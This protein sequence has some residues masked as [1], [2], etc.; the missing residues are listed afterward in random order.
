MGSPISK[1]G[2]ETPIRSKS[3]SSTG[4]RDVSIHRAQVLNVNTRDYTVDVRYESYPY[5]THSDIP[6][7]V[8]YLH[9]N[10]GEGIVAMPEVGSTVWVC[11]PSESGKDAFV[12]GWTPVQET[13]TYRAGRV[14]LNPGDINLSTRDGN[15]VTIRR[16]GIVQIGSTP[17]CQRLFIP[18][19]NVIRDFAENYELTTPAGDLTWQVLREENSGD[20]HSPC[21]FTLECK[22]F[23]DDPNTN[24]LATLKIGSHGDGNNTILTLESRDK[25]GGSIKTSLTIDKSG[26]IQWTSQGDVSLILKGNLSISADQKVI[27]ASKQ[28]MSFTSVTSILA[29]APS[30]SFVAGAASFSL[31]GSGA[32]IAGVPVSLGDAQGPVVIDNG[33][34]ANWIMAVTTALTANVSQPVGTPVLKV[35]IPP[36]TYKSTKVKA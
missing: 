9:Q 8:P 1:P 25:G 18:I 15:F 35:I 36:V 26:K 2:G 27:V 31:S 13:G 30:I 4:D 21:S 24:P 20:G 28:D 10:Q 17:I 12:L 19:R 22:E 7:M 16:G 23:S 5:S 34:L 32:N 33:S 6:W 11:Q 3:S 14:L 29:Q